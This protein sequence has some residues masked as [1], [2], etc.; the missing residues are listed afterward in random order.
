MQDPE[1]FLDMLL[2]EINFAKEQ[3]RNGVFKMHEKLTDEAAIYAKNYLEANTRYRIE[4][5]KCRQCAFEWDI[6]VIF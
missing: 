3:G 5:H 1:Q 4:F 2:S 6:M